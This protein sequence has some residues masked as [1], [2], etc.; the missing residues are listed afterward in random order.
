MPINATAASKSSVL[1]VI[2]KIF[3]LNQGEL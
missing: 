3:G 2:A 1:V